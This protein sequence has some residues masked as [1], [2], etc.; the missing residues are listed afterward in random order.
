[1]SKSRSLL[2]YSALAYAVLASCAL[3]AETKA[4]PLIPNSSIKLVGVEL[5][6]VTYKGRKAMQVTH[7]EGED[8]RSLA[9][10][11]GIDFTDGIIEYDF[12]GDVKPGS[13]DGFRGF[14]GLAFRVQ[15][16][17]SEY[18][19]F[20]QRPRNGRSENQE[21]RNHSVQYISMPDFPWQR[22][23][24][25][26]PGRYE[27]YVDMVPGEWTHVRIEVHGA[28]ALLFVNHATQPVLIVNDLK[29]GIS[30]GTLAL[31]VDVG[32]VAHFANL[33]I[34]R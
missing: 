19:C 24:M 28:R 31:W 1:M 3:H 6:S 2:R 33:R 27:S 32:T 12:A 34:T 18:E 10:L 14:S 29:H 4:I 23:R 22:L 16:G 25:E 15:P 5:A 21:Q 30:H 13:G 17:G 20:Y 26:T 11:P 8:G 7:R 9:I